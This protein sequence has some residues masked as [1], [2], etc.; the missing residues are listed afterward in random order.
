MDD[1]VVEYIV[2]VNHMVAAA[3][4][5]VVGREYNKR[6]FCHA[7]RIEPVEYAPDSVVGLRNYTI[8]ER[9]RP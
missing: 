7:E 6:I 5:A 1:V 9:D 8:I 4:I 2:L 3:H